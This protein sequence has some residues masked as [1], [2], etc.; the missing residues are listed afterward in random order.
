MFDGSRKIPFK[1]HSPWNRA[2]T[3]LL[4]NPSVTNS[5]KYVGFANITIYCIV[6]EKLHKQIILTKTLEVFCEINRN[7]FLEICQMMQQFFRRI[8]M[9]RSHFNEI[10]RQ[11]YRNLLFGYPVG[12][13]LRY[14][15]NTFLEEFKITMAEKIM[16]W[17]FSEQPFN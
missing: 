9:S 8:S 12:D 7:S 16:N 2:I 6:H 17:R 10:T 13:V 15:R 4:L 11:L 3:F 1:L 14:L 5:Q